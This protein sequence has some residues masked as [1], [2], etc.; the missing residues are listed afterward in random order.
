MLTPQHTVSAP[1]PPPAQLFYNLPGPWRVSAGENPLPF[2]FNT[3]EMLGDKIFTVVVQ[4]LCVV[5]I[6]NLK[7]GQEATG[8]RRKGRA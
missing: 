1:P 6:G 2:S 7:A 3:P 5:S 8:H 4:A